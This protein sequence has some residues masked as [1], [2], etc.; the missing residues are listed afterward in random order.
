MKMMLSGN[1]TLWEVNSGMP[2]QSSVSTGCLVQSKHRVY[3]IFEIQLARARRFRKAL[4]ITV[5][6][7]SPYNLLH[8][9]PSPALPLRAWREAPFWHLVYHFASLFPFWSVASTT[10]KNLPYLLV[11]LLLVIDP[12][13]HRICSESSVFSTHTRFT[14]RVYTQ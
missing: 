4:I 7:P 10:M 1:T 9:F 5:F 13:I 3:R 2:C 12:G 11:I 14:I 8:E 6:S